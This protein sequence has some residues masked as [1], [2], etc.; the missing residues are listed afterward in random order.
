MLDKSP[1]AFDTYGED[2]ISDEMQQVYELFTAVIGRLTYHG[3]S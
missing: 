3:K 1:A 2:K